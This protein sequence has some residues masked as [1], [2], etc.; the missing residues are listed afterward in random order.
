MSALLYLE[1][2]VFLVLSIYAQAGNI[3]LSPLL[4]NAL[5][6]QGRDLNELTPLQGSITRIFALHFVHLLVSVFFSNLVQGKISLMM[7]EQ[8][9]DLGV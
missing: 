8:D 1:G 7:A 6:P 4:Q 9:T 3:F 5:S 2:L